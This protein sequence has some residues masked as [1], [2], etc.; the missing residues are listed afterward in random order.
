M[1]QSAAL[2]ERINFANTKS[3]DLF[4]SIHAASG[5]AFAVY[6]SALVDVNVD[7]AIKLYGL[8]SRQGV[9]LPASKEAAQTLAVNLKKDFNAEVVLRELPLPVLNSLNAPA[10]LI[11]YPSLKSYA[12][13]QKM[14][15]KFVASLLKGISLYEQ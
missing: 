9:H 14:R 2:S 8:S 13:D 15:D 6:V 3:P 5:D 1:D 10:V 4:I 12:S 11:E 7:S